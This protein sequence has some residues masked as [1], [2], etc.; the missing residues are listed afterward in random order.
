LLFAKTQK[1]LGFD[2]LIEK[3]FLY[4]P[5][6]KQTPQHTTRFKETSLGEQL[7]STLSPRLSPHMC[8]SLDSIKQGGH[9]GLSVVE[10]I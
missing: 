2:A 8:L 1:I 9:K 6:K 4:K 10:D 5:K 7:A 3:R